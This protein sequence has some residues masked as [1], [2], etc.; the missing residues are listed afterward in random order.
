MPARG[1]AELSM[2][3]FSIQGLVN[4]PSLFV[5]F[6]ISVILYDLASTNPYSCFATS[7]ESRFDC[8]SL[9]QP[10]TASSFAKYHQS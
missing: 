7:M 9:P 5:V 2:N 1:T 6:S 8:Q 3:Q 10:R 4:T